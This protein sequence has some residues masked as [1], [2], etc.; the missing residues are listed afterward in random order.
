MSWLINL[1]KNNPTYPIAFAVALFV[2]QAQFAFAQ[3]RVDHKTLEEIKEIVQGQAAKAE[4][5]AKAEAQKWLFIRKACLLKT[6][7]DPD[8]CAEAE[9]RSR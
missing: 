9:A 7:N 8:K 4:A 2:A 3:Q 6:L 1:I 5:D